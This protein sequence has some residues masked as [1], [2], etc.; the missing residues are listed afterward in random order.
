[1][2]AA[3]RALRAAARE[4]AFD[5]ADALAWAVDV[6]TAARLLALPMRD[7]PLLRRWLRAVIHRDAESDRCR[8]APGAAGR[9]LRGYLGALRGRRGRAVG[10]VP[11]AVR[12][13]ARLPLAV[14]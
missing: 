8:R 2:R 7:E 11:P 1:V 3:R 12:G 5:A 13:V 10:P 6:R 4:G 14:D 9:E